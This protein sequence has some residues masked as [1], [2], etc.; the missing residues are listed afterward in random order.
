MSEKKYVVLQSK[1][2][3]KDQKEQFALDIL[4]G[5]SSIPKSIPSK[6]FY[7][8][9]GSNLFQQITNLEEYYLTK[10][11]FEIL[12]KHKDE[13]TSTF[14]DIEFNLVDLGAGD[15]RKTIILLKH[16]IK[17]GL[18]FTYF[19]ID[20]SENTI[21]E[22]TETLEKKFN[23]KLDFQ[24]IVGEYFN[25]LTWLNNQS[26]KPNLVLFLGSNIGNFTL[27]E[28]QTFLFHLWNSLKNKDYL[29]TGFDLKKD[30]EILHKAYNDSKN[31]TKEFNL[32]LLDR[33]NRE[34]GA[35][36]DRT[37]FIHHTNYNAERGAM[38]SWL[39]STVAQKA[40]IEVLHKDFCFEE[41]EGT[42]TEFS[43]KYTPQVIEQLA[44]D[45]GFI[46]KKLFFDSKKFFCD[47]L[48][49]IKKTDIK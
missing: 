14:K 16:F 24:G 9:K 43:Y 23:K 40:H 15:A 36:F 45:T 37:K 19:P 35:N 42:R 4:K 29:L 7:D 47:A 34:L 25:A 10:Y 18:K 44:D 12:N 48:W 33:M 2:V 46:V 1:N 21:A 28:A 17:L 32:N 39:I 26:G 38:E 6:Y 49:Q 13:I 31:V 27:I 20:I 11:E 22:L 8:E 3:E 5:L 30:L 41:W